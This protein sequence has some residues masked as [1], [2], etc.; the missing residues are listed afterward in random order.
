[1]AADTSSKQ[2]LTLTVMRSVLSCLLS[3][4][5]FLPLG[6]SFVPTARIN[7]NPSCSSHDSSTCQPVATRRRPG[8]QAG[9]DWDRELDRA[10][11]KESL[12][13]R[14]GET[15]AGAVLGGLLLG[16]FGA[17]FGASVGASLGRNQAIDQAREEEMKRL[18]LSKDMLEAA[19]EVGLALERN[20]EGLKAVQESFDTQKRLARRIDADAE[21]IYSKA[22]EALVAGDEESARKYLLERTNL[23]EKLK[24]VLKICATAKQQVEV[25][26]SNTAVLEQRAMEM[27]ALMRRTVGAKAVQDSAESGMSLSRSDPLLDKFRDMGID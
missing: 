11:E 25:M 4:L 3:G 20:M 17:L 7:S 15:V 23:Q 16:P 21:A 18:G 14:P 24:E 22:K 13:A 26:Q 12:K 6:Q 5:F 1:M 10:Q 8:L 27:D 19:Q 9:K 2:L